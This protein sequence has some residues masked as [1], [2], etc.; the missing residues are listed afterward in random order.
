MPE[1]PVNRNLLFGILALQNNFISR[2]SL[3]SA[4][5]VW[6]VDKRRRLGEI[7]LEQGKLPKALDDLISALVEQH[8]QLHSND[9]ERSLAALSTVGSIRNDLQS[10]GDPQ[11]EASLGAIAHDSPA[12]TNSGMD[13]TT[14]WSSEGRRFRILRPLARGG[15]GEV[16]VAHDLE[17]HRE[18][19]L[20]EIQSRFVANSNSR[21]RF[22]QEAEITGSLEHPGIVPVYGLGQYADGRPFYAMRFIRG[23]NLSQAIAAFHKSEGPSRDRGLRSVE[24]RQLLGRFIDVCQAIEY[25]HSRGILH[26]DLKPGNIMLGKYGETLVV[27]WGLAKSVART[28]GDQEIDETTLR[29][30]TSDEM[31]E[32]AMG[33]AIGTPGYM[34]P[35]QAAGRLEELG[36]T[37]DVYSLGATLYCVLTGRPPVQGNDKGEVLMKVQ[38][39][40][41]PRPREIKPDVPAALQA[42]CL[43]AMMTIPQQRYSSARKLAEDLELWLADE[44][45]SAFRDPFLVRA[46]RTIRKH[47]SVFV[48]ALT[49]G[50]LGLI[51]LSIF[52]A[53]LS[54]KNSELASAYSLAE[55]NRKKAELQQSLAETNAETAQSAA[56]NI[57]EIAELRLSS[58]PGQE[59]F[60]ESMM[61]QVH[62]LYSKIHAEHPKDEAVEWQLAKLSRL[63]GNVKRLLLKLSDSQQLLSQSLALQTHLAQRDNESRR[64]LAET[65]RD[66]ATLAKL[67]GDLALATTSF[68]S[69]GAIIIELLKESPAD[70]DL[71]GISATIDLESVALHLDLLNETA[72]LEAAARCEGTLLELIEKS[73]HRDSD[74][75]A[76]LFAT[77]RLGQVLTK[78]GRIEESQSVYDAGVKRGR[79]W[80]EIS[81]SP[82]LRRAF[83]RLLMYQATDLAEQEPLPD[84]A[85]SL[86]VEAIDRY[87]IL[88]NAN[89]S[90]SIR[91]YLAAAY[92]TQGIIAQKNGEQERAIQAYETSVSL[93]EKLVSESP[94]ADSHQQLASS[95]FRLGGYYQLTQ[96]ISKAS[97]LY[98]SAINSQQQAVALKPASLADRKSLAF[99]QHALEALK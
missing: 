81:A 70:A 38:R 84:H 40:D 92:R 69:A 78:L 76:T 93:L 99:Y 2:D 33:S 17:L 85:E 1:T 49:F 86:I 39:G 11:L 41:F 37:S 9:P 21:S 89:P 58:T 55:V 88:V 96:N 42:I 32:T 50:V 65:Y 90:P 36:P 52:T 27:D 73:Q 28:N 62:A 25:A 68:E 48:I 94:T 82:D 26:R 46:G 66:Q 98:Q 19:A 74:Y 95:Q 30:M 7:L 4:F 29:P 61:D 23:D 87:N 43:K 75:F 51:I 44:P 83:A 53:I 64:Y 20:K 54:R 3:V 63:T 35:E 22:V 5:A 13:S 77:S 79:A 24:L 80:L 71:R 8:L 31:D 91:T 10:L 47:K 16:Y 15:L 14:V 18:V 97:A 12:G 57:A 34:S 56:L 59:G 45:I 67:S 60:R 6:I 72:A